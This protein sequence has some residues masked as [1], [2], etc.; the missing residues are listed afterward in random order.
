MSLT[1]IA[2]LYGPIGAGAFLVLIIVFSIVRI[3][4]IIPE[5]SGEWQELFFNAY[6]ASLNRIIFGLKINL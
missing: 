2:W 3:T 5:T 4:G 6:W 1:T